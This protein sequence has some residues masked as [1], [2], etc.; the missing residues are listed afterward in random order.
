MN[1]K[2]VFISHITEESE[3]AVILSEEIKKSYLGM[4][5]TFVSSDGQSLPAG[6]RWIDQ[7]DTALNQSAIQISL[8]S[9]QSIKR[10]WINFEAGA[11]WIRKI[12]VV[13]VCHSGLTKGDLPIPLAMLQAADISN[14]TDLEIM[15]N[16]LTK[17]LGATKTPNIDYDSIISSAKEFEHKYTYVARVKNAIFSVINTCP[18]LKDLFLSGSI[19]STPLQI[20]DFQYNEMAKHLDFL[21]DNELLAY[22]FNQTLITGDGTFKG[23]NVSVT[24]AYLNNV[25]EL[26]R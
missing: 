8:C 15:F 10:P 24:S 26:V 20:K 7:I 21:K 19:Q 11:S 4:L 16:E 5:D 3:L 18:Q 6:G 17:I 9:P 2:L 12:P 14:R 23:G 25:I 13:P 1:K 22:G